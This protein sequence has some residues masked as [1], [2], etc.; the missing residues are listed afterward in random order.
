MFLL[1]ISGPWI[2]VLGAVF[3][4][5]V[6]VQR[7]TE[8]L[9]AGLDSSLVEFRITRLARVFHALKTSVEKLASYYKGLEGIYTSPV[10]SRYFPWINSYEEGGK[11]VRFEY[12][13]YLEK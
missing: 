11:E 9:W 7:L 10:P 3:I 8:G 4:D 12:L 1:G 13:G 6:I 5:G 2:T